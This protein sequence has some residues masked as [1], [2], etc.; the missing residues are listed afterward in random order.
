ME[1]ELE[2]RHLVVL[3]ELEQNEQGLVLDIAVLGRHKFLLELGDGPLDQINRRLTAF[4][5]KFDHADKCRA[6]VLVTTTQE[7]LLEEAV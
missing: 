3:F 6:D 4:F 7:G 2:A 5:E 1:E